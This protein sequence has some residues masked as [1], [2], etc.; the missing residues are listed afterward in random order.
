MESTVSS[1]VLNHRA[2]CLHNL[3]NARNRTTVLF[4][5]HECLDVLD[6]FVVFRTLA[7]DLAQLAAKIINGFIALIVHPGVDFIPNPADLLHLV[8]IQCGAELN[9]FGSGEKLFDR[10]RSVMNSG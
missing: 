7:S 2:S 3:C 4:N 8:S 9:D 6:P 10:S 1:R 5:A